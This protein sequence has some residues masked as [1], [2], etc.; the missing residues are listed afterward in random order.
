LIETSQSALPPQSKPFI[1]CSYK[2]G[3]L[4]CQWRAVNETAC[5]VTQRRVKG[6]LSESGG[7]HKRAYCTKGVKMSGSNSKR[8]WNI[9]LYILVS[10]VR[11]KCRDSQPSVNDRMHIPAVCR[12]KPRKTLVPSQ[13]AHAFNATGSRVDHL[14][15]HSVAYLFNV[16]E[17]IWFA[18]LQLSPYLQPSEAHQW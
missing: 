14:I 15:S 4:C 12:P 5:E 17:D 18:A 8:T 7:L 16:C 1:G 11:S 2:E 9:H 13:G 6:V 3:K 10:R